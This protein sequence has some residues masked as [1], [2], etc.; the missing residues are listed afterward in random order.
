MP[1][2]GLLIQARHGA[3][4]GGAAAAKGQM[5]KSVSLKAAA[6]TFMTTFAFVA[7]LGFYSVSS[8]KATLFEGNPNLRL[9]Q[10]VNREPL[11]ITELAP[12]QTSNNELYPNYLDFPLKPASDLEDWRLD[13]PTTTGKP[14]Q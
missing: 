14:T 4:H 7:I 11:Y 3:R 9:V 8:P 2:R 10:A 13:T 5:V 12:I 6:L 1:G